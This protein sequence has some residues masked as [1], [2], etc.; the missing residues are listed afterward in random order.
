MPSPV[1]LHSYRASQL[2]IDVDAE[3]QRNIAH[4]RTAGHMTE[5]CSCSE[6]N[7]ARTRRVNEF[8]QQPPGYMPGCVCPL[9]RDYRAEVL[10]GYRQM[11]AHG[12][13][14]EL[15]PQLRAWATGGV[16]GS[17]LGDILGPSI[18]DQ[19]EV[20][21]PAPNFDLTAESISELASTLRRERAFPVFRDEAP[22][23]TSMYTRVPDTP[24]E[25]NEFA[26]DMARLE[27]NAADTRGRSRS[28][29]PIVGVKP[30]AKDWKPSDWEA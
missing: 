15:T 21:V 14:V 2:Q 23:L 13:H 20:V 10:N 12:V 17:S 30:V 25:I 16:V 7:E 6:C 11:E 18:L 19:R 1:N 27:R 28:A 3:V 8:Y 4:C 5:A 9:C 29:Q 24:D 26:A 22:A